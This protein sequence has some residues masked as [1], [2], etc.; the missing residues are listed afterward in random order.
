MNASPN[1]SDTPYDR[2][3]AAID[4]WLDA[5]HSESADQ[6]RAE[7]AQIAPTDTTDAILRRLDTALE[8]LEGDATRLHDRGNEEQRKARA[9]EEQAMDSI[10][11]GDDRAAQEALDQ[12]NEHV[13]RATRHFDDA[14][15]LRWMLN[16]YRTAAAAI[17]NRIAGER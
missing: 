16:Q 1:D 11:A 14:L 2:L 17:R 7:L 5:F 10:R 3:R 15:Q 9:L 4:E 6:V 8:I 13:T 12:Q